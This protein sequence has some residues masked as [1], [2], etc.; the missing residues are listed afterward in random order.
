MAMIAETKHV[1][2]NLY[3][4]DEDSLALLNAITWRMER[5]GV[6][7]K[8]VDAF[9]EEATS[10]GRR[11]LL[12]TCELWVTLVCLSPA[13]TRVKSYYQPTWSPIDEPPGTAIGA[14]REAGLAEDICT[15]VAQ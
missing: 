15:D 12:E 3:G 13:V 8:V 11:H 7:D 5:D 14:F 6:S 2:V 10:K 9:S 1:V 4:V